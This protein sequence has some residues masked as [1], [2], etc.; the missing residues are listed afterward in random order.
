MIKNPSALPRSAEDCNITQHNVQIKADNRRLLS[1]MRFID[2]AIEEHLLYR[3]LPSL[4]RTQKQILRTCKFD[5]SVKAL[6][7]KLETKLISLILQRPDE[8]RCGTSSKRI[9]RRHFGARHC[10]HM[11]SGVYPTAID[12]CAVDPENAKDA[13]KVTAENLAWSI[14]KQRV[15]AS[16]KFWKSRLAAV[17]RF[18]K[19]FVLATCFPDEEVISTTE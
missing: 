12:V 18:F 7:C 10:R 9:Y 17:Q 14:S 11:F 4:L 6:M 5:I 8:K 1:H 3:A 15:D 2:C 19:G 16:A 13:R